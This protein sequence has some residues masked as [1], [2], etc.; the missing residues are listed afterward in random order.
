LNLL[1]LKR[2][3]GWTFQ[4]SASL[5]GSV[6]VILAIGAG[7]GSVTLISPA[8]TPVIFNYLSA[9]VGFGMGAKISISGSTEDYLSIGEIWI[10]SSFSGFEL[11]ARDISGA[12]MVADISAAMLHGV[13]GSA[14]L[15]G[16]DPDKVQ[17]EFF[18]DIGQLVVA[19]A[20]NGNYTLDFLD[21]R[22]WFESR[23]R[24]V[25][26]MGGVSKGANIGAGVMGSL[27]Y[28][29]QGTNSPDVMPVPV[30]PRRENIPLPYRLTAAD[31][32]NPIKLPGDALFDFDKFNLKPSAIIHLQVAG[33]AIKSSPGRRIV[34]E[35]HTD[36][37]GPQNYNIELSKKRANAVKDWLV[38]Q[39]YAASGDIQTFGYGAQYPVASNATEEGR[40]KNRRVELKIVRR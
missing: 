8:G 34:L 9:G 25:L 31:D 4:T 17:T 20:P 32:P 28:L 2:K 37:I 30:M 5:S 1:K 35:G 38:A 13:S 33:R 21:A 16:V 39:G 6:E 11:S 26:F 15:M 19:M 27:G 24:A 3:S 12:I 40:Q 10:L 7:K 29:W 23:A 14:M 22:G 18:S 36:S